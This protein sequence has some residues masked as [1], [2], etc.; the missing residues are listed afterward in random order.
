MA[1]VHQPRVDVRLHMLFWQLADRWGRVR[2]DGISVPLRLT[3]T[4]LA[5]LVAARR[6]TVTSALS[7]LADRGVLRAV[8]GAWLLSGEPPGELLECGEPS[9][10]PNARRARVTPKA[11][12]TPRR[13]VVIILT[14]RVGGAQFAV[15][16]WAAKVN[17]R[18]EAGVYDERS[19]RPQTRGR[20]LAR[21]SVSLPRKIRAVRNAGCPCLARRPSAPAGVR[22]R[23][24]R[25]CAWWPIPSHVQ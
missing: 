8:D 12:A 15:R 6:P 23:S 19:P 7:E 17:A 2:S 10:S 22:A 4:V 24:S 16:S 21:A 14:A 20:G 9:R 5:E 25:V 11:G 13:H 3:H 18:G 1:I